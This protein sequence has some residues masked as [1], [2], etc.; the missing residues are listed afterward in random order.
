MATQSKLLIKHKLKSKKY[1]LKY[2]MPC[3]AE[4]IRKGEIT[5][6]KFEKL[7]DDLVK[8]KEIPDEDLYKLFPV[9]MNFIPD[10]AKKKN[11]FDGRVAI[12]DKD[13]VRQYFWYDHD[14]IVKKRMNPGREKYC[15]VLPAII[16]EVNGKIGIVQTPLDKREVSLSFIGAENMKN[17]KVTVHYYHACEKIS[18]KEFEGLWKIKS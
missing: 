13:V 7:C 17:K 10:S 14:D 2:A 4:R 16:K 11:K 12:I 8:D 6:K 5:Q 15:F 1:F 9:A 3:L 18:D